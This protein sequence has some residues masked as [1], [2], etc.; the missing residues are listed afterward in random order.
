MPAEA[1]AIFDLDSASTLLEASLKA[2]ATRSSTI[3]WSASTL[4][5]MRT[6]R[7]S[8]VPVRVTLTMPAPALPV[9]SSLASSSWARCRFSCIFCAC[10]ISWAILPR[11]GSVLV[12]RADGVRH[13]AGAMLLDQAA[14]RRV[15]VEGLL[16]GGLA[17][18]A[19]AVL[20]LM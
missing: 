5:S 11:M 17:R 6:L 15:A 1:A 16:G 12:Y 9:T 10:C 4:G 2:A 8:L 13:H 18:I 7:H 20:A 3:S 14:H 19:L